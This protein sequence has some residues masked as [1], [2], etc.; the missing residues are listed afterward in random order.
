MALQIKKYILY[1]KLFVRRYK[2]SWIGITLWKIARV[3]YWN[4]HVKPL[5]DEIFSIV[6]SNPTSS[7]IFFKEDCQRGLMERSWKPSWMKYAT[8][9]SNHSSSANLWDVISV[10]L[11]WSDRKAQKSHVRRFVPLPIP[12]YFL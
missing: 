2:T 11:W 6:G 7:T 5:W 10:M 3:D 9:C 8:E 12:K 4:G 1:I